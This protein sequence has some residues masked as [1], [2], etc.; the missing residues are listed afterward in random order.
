MADRALKHGGKVIDVLPDFS[1]DK[2]VAHPSLRELISV[3]TMHE[4]KAKMNGLCDGF[5][6]LPGDLVLWKNYLRF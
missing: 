1:K 4:R 5:I 2:E 6:T 3:D